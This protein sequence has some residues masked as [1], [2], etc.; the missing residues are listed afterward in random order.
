M[1]SQHIE[2]PTSATLRTLALTYPLSHRVVHLSTLRRGNDGA[3]KVRSAIEPDELNIHS[4]L[5]LV[6]DDEHE[7]LEATEGPRPFRF[8]NG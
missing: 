1:G 4:A 2:N 6:V 5:G 8:P 7:G 3:Q